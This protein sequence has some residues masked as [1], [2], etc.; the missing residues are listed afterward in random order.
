MYATPYSIESGWGTKQ[1]K[2]IFEFALQHL[3]S[4]A[5]NRIMCLFHVQTS[6]DFRQG[7]GNCNFKSF[8]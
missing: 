1:L 5:S 4:P 3:V 8:V 7:I 2:S 6:L